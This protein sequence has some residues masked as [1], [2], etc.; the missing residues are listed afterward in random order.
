VTINKDQSLL[1]LFDNV[2]VRYITT[3]TTLSTIPDCKLVGNV[4]EDLDPSGNV[5]YIDEQ[6]N[7][8][9]YSLDDTGGLLVDGH[10][11]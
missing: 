9:E 6:A 2:G 3:T 4:E 5:T 10:V 8:L 11:Q 7:E 1:L